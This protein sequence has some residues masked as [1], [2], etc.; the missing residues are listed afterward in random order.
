MILRLLSFA[1]C[2]G[3][4]AALAAAQDLGSSNK[5][6]GGGKTSSKIKGVKKTPAKRKPVAK[7]PVAKKET[8]VAAKRTKPVTSPGRRV[9]STPAKNPNAA[10]TPVKEAPTARFARTEPSRS[11]ESPVLDR[12]A[13]ERFE[14]LIEDGN[15]ARDNRDYVAAEQA[16]EK[17]RSIN[18]RDARS[19]YGL[20]NLYSDQQRWDEAERFY[21]EALTLD[22]ADA[23]AHIALSYVLTQP[24]AAPN[25]AERYEEAEK[26]ARRA[27]ELAPSNPLALDQLGVT[28]ELRGQ[29]GPETESYYR[30]AIRLDP[31]LAPPYA[32]LGRLLRR[33]GLTKE[34]A[35]AYHDAVQRSTDVGTMILVAEV[36]QSEQRFAESEDLLSSALNSDP[37]N[38]SALLLLGRALTARGSFV[39]AEK[40][41]KRSLDVSSNGFRP[42]L[43][44]ASLY[45]RQGKNELAENA[46]LQALR[47]VP[48]SEKRLLAQQFELVGDAYL[49]SGK[50]QKAER[51]YQQAKGLDPENGSL[52]AKLAKT[53]GG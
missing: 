2:I 47:T 19:V 32:H 36:M 6:F 39:E 45:W 17:A 37:R 33:R 42:N 27:V 21:R 38:P 28:M 8:S 22:P 4:F 31:P 30:R 15:A 41:L 52:T 26:L 12:T 50:R 44:L 1:V 20:G 9:V 29:I 10:K 53:Y 5:L 40:L 43:M 51:S 7:T 18:P 34:S 35:A 14:K 25:L 24:I 13:A 3:M 48:N 11:K 23:V 16:Y 46:L 49:K